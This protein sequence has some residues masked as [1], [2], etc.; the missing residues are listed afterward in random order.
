MAT[1]PNWYMGFVCQFPKCILCYCS[2]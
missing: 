1:A 2:I